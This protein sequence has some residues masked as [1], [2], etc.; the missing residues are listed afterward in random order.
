M[1]RRTLERP[2]IDTIPA[3]SHQAAP[4]PSASLAVPA[5]LT[6]KDAGGA[7]R[8]TSVRTREVSATGVVVECDASVALPLYRLV[9]LQV[10]KTARD[11]SGLPQPLRDGRVLSAVWQVAPCKPSTGTPAGYALRFMTEPMSRAEARRA[12]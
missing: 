11:V 7:V 12:S 1:N 5:R 9:H 10:E 8:F 2:V 4:C 6:W 3:R